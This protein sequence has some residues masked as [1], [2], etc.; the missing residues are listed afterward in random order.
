MC[1]FLLITRL[2]TR[3]LVVY[4]YLAIKNEADCSS[5]IIYAAKRSNVDVRMTSTMPSV[6]KQFTTAESK[7]WRAEI[8]YSVWPSDGP[9]T[10]S[11]L[12]NLRVTNFVLHTV[13]ISPA[14]H[15][16]TPLSLSRSVSLYLSSSLAFKRNS[17]SRDKNS[18]IIYSP[19]CRSKPAWYSFFCTTRGEIEECW[20]CL[21]T[22]EA[23]CDP[24]PSNKHKNAQLKTI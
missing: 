18:V 23:Y 2:V 3:H 13:K 7:L 8:K 16:R 5:P 10:Q 17:S 19:S 21:N 22:M 1:T 6:I 15:S 14:P 24:G 11:P 4:K 20:C 12:N 9:E